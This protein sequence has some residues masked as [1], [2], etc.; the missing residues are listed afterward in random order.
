MGFNSKT[1]ALVPNV[2]LY[3]QSKAVF[4]YSDGLDLFAQRLPTALWLIATV[5]GAFFLARHAAGPTAAYLAATLTALDPNLLAHSSLLTVDVAFAAATAL[6]VL[7]FLSLAKQP[8][9][10]PAV[11]LG[12]A[13]GLALSAKFTALLLLVLPI[14]LP[15]LFPSMRISRPKDIIRLLF[16]LLLAV[17]TACV[18]INASYLFASV[19]TPLKDINFVHPWSQKAAAVLPNLRLPLPADF[20]TGIDICFQA[21]R[22]TSWNTVLLGTTS[23]TGIW[24]YFLAV[25]LMKTPLLAIALSI[26]G[27]L[28]LFRARVLVSSPPIRFIALSLGLFLFYFSFIFHTQVGFRYVLFCLPPFY[29]L[30][31]AGLAFWSRSSWRNAVLVCTILSSAGELSAYSGNLLAYTN[32]FVQPKAEAYRF[33]ADSNIDWGQ[34]RD[35]LSQWLEQAGISHAPVDPPHILPGVNIFSLN[36]L[37]GVWW[38]FDEHKWARDNLRPTTH[39]G[40][41]FIRFDVDQEKFASFL[42]DERTLKVPS[43]L[44]D[45]CRNSE[46]YQPL[47]AIEFQHNRTSGEIFCLLAKATSLVRFAAGLSSAQF[48]VVDNHGRCKTKQLQAGEQ[49]WYRLKPG[50]HAFCIS[51]KSSLLVEKISGQIQFSATLH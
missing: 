24:Y 23:G 36:E 3:R 26:C 35:K 20:L 46:P 7:S 9:V 41:T 15:I 4:H 30:V 42:R 11:L 19:L 38:N 32:I 5:A 8:R 39:Y 1:P 31:G 51:N 18:V 29:A 45:Q 37:A 2:W 27:M 48:G 43:L 25:W 33:L 10:L 17:C 50:I 21:E 22:G 47:A 34:N 49:S 13:L 14:L 28:V 6:A 16:F 12:A 44:P 40:Y